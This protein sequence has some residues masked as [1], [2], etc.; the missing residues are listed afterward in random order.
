MILPIVAYGSKILRQ[1]T[2]EIDENYENLAQLIENM[3]ETMDSADGVGLAAPQVG[4][5]IRLFIIDTSPMKDDDPE[6]DN[7][8]KVFI[9]PII[10]E[11]WGKE[12]LFNEGCLSVPDIREDIK[13]KPNIRIE[14]YDENFKLKEEV[15]DGVKARVIQHEYDH[16]EGLIFTDHVSMLKKKLLK[17]KLNSITKGKISLRYKM[18][19][20]NKKG[21]LA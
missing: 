11:E 3:F 9:N 4:Y 18:R 8:R 2:D 5:A 19:F 20:P 12:W 14:Y 10:I 1:E 15:F 13:R 16:L 17:S 7:F 6:L 21:M